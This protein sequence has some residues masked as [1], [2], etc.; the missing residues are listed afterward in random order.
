MSAKVVIIVLVLIA[1]LFA[2]VLVAGSRRKRDTTA[3]TER[4]AWAQL[5]KKLY[6]EQRVE[7]S[8]VN[9]NCLAGGAFQLNA[10]AVCTAA[11]A[12]S[13]KRVRTAS[14]KLAQGSEAKVI[15]KPNAGDGKATGDGMAVPVQTKLK[16]GKETKFQIMRKG[17]TLQLVCVSGSGSP[18]R[19]MIQLD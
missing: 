14:L 4:S 2:L 1:L 6:Q 16:A 18:G 11:V 3:D 8:E 7:P 12:A 15:Y 19:C 17:G 13:E 5:F 9:A 10:G